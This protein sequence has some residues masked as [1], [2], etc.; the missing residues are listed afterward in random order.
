MSVSEVFFDLAE[1]ALRG[2]E[3]AGDAGTNY[4]AGVRASFAQWGVGGVNTYLA[5]A[6]ST[7]IDYN[8]A[9]YDNEGD[10]TINDFTSRSTVS[11]AWDDAATNE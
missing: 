4:D 3:G 8:V 1:A 6:T 5:D 11:I 9:V 2:W 7:P 10:G